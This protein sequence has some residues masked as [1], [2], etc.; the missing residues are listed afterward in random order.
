[1]ETTVKASVWA[2]LMALWIKVLV[3]CTAVQAAFG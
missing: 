3:L 1:M 2:S